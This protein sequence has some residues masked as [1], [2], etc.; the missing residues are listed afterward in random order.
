MGCVQSVFRQTGP[1]PPRADEK[2][3]RSHSGHQ[4]VRRRAGQNSPQGTYLKRRFYLCVCV[5]VKIDRSIAR[6]RGPVNVPL[7]SPSFGETC[8]FSHKV[9]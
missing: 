6:N 7:L 2:D 1:L 8:K 3:E 4:Q 5:P 9:Q